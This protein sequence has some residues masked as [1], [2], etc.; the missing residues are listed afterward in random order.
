MDIGRLDRRIVIEYPTNTNVMGDRTKTWS[1]L[2]TVWATMTFPKGLSSNEGEEQGRETAVTPVEFWV[3][4]RA[5]IN[6]TMRVSYG[7]EYY[8]ITRVNSPDRFVSL[9]LVTEKRV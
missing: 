5:D 6:E 8:Y 9:K 4:Y 3:R 2:C 7:D 1:T